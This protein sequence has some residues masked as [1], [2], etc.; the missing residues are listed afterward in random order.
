MK[1][2]LFYTI[3]LMSFYL[4]VLQFILCSFVFATGIVSGQSLDD[5]KLSLDLHDVS[6]KEAFKQIKNQ[7]GFNF[8]YLQGELHE[9]E[10]LDIH[11]RDK[12]LKEV[13]QVIA[14]QKKLD[15]KRV[16][17]LIVVKK[18]KFEQP[19]IYED[20]LQTSRIITGKIIDA[21]TG[22][23]LP[24]VNV[25]IKNTNTGV[26]N[27]I[28]GNY[29]IE[30][31][32]ELSILVF[33]SVG[34]VSQE[35]QI[36][37]Q[38]VINVNLNED[39]KVL[40]ELVVVGYGSQSGRD[41]TG[42]VTKIDSKSIKDFQ[43]S[44]FTEALAGQ[45]PGVQVL[46][47]TGVPGAAPSI[48]IRGVGSITA[49][50]EPLYVVDGFPMGN[51][52]LNMFNTNDIE[53][54]TVLKDASATSI[55]GSRGSNGVILITTKRG[56]S[57]KPQLTFDSYI[58]F[59]QVAKKMDVLSPEEYAEFTMDASNNGWATLGGNINDP[60]ELRPA[61]YRNSPYLLEPEKWDRTDWQDEIFRTAPIQNYEMTVSGGNEYVNY[62]VS[63]GY[64]DQDG[65]VENTNFKRYSLRTNIDTKISDRLKLGIGLNYS[66]IDEQLVSDHGTWNR[67]VIGTAIGLPGFFAPINEDGSYSDHRGF[68]FGVSA[69]RNPMIFI[70][71]EKRQ[72][73][74]SRL[75][76]NMFIEYEL[77]KGLM[78]R[79]SINAD[80]F[81]SKLNYFRNETKFGNAKIPGHGSGILPSEGSYNASSDLNWLMEN[82][83]NY[84][85]EL[86][87][88][89]RINALIGYTAQK[90]QL[91][92]AS[93]NANNFQNNLVP[94]LNA[95][96]VTGA[97]TNQ[98]EWSLLSYLARIN[99]SFNETY[100]ATFTVRRDGS[101]RFGADRKWGVFPSASI[102]WIV[103]EE[104]F[105]AGSSF[106][107][108]LKIR[109]SYGLSGNDAIPNYGSIGLLAG[110]DYVIGNQPI[111]GLAQSTISNSDLSWENSE[112]I[113]I[114]IEFGVLGNRI[115]IVAD[116]FQR[117]TQ[118]LLLNVNVPSILGF[119]NSLQ[120]IGKVRNRGM[121]LTLM[122]KNSTSE[123]KWST[124]FNI[125]FIRNKV[126]ALGP[127]GDPIIS[128]T[129]GGSSTHITQVGRPMGEFFGYI[130]DGIY[131]SQEEINSRPSLPTDEPGSPIILDVN[132]DNEITT[133]DRTVIGNHYPN[134]VYGVKNAFSY[135]NFDLNIFI[136]GVQGVDIMNVG[137]R[138][139][140]VLTGRTNQLG[141]ARERWR[142]PEQP[143][144]GKVP[145]ANIDVYGVVRDP[146]TF[147]VED[148]SYLRIRNVTIGYTLNRSL[149]DRIGLG[150]ARV[151]ASAMNLLTLSKN[152]DFNPEISTF[153]SGLTPGTA[154]I[155]YPVARTVSFGINLTF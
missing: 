21:Q 29:S 150:N 10:R 9:K 92:S 108:Y 102:G 66:L 35:I 88:N 12:S 56:K 85:L 6:I 114:G 45:V 13:L 129:Y 95:G 40:D 99:Y 151:Y 5:V 93:I 80:R 119:T 137:K 78:F 8:I 146:S 152:T 127:S 34:Y 1:T 68:G 73:D 44:T 23:P 36:G 53:S 116:L 26:I 90:A 27:D 7:T 63:G 143:G 33:S 144:N 15:F 28:D 136:Q 72:R 76:A 97:G 133:A 121:E 86:R 64:F 48:R 149:V 67:G 25:V 83:L 4:L 41:I 3:I 42:S 57:G 43:T 87:K 107:D 62:R 118:D 81:D 140:M 128:T 124:D 132:N 47:T 51:D 141:E 135:K 17:K 32:N 11:A 103:S 147:Y 60:N 148:G 134:F 49:G 84:D 14:N 55:Y 104:S 154:D 122:T 106:V 155:N 100:Y 105:M 58:G 50:N 20:T 2:R 111:T 123:F 142:S 89:H 24:G 120:N 18:S 30:V 91:G 145:K 109:G 46:Q 153:H 31:P 16:N 98:Q 110:Y 77:L 82:T 96:E 94:T 138:Q 39:S 19:L 22:T 74:Q 125:S 54:I 112:Q 79:S 65:V 113:D 37:N 38:S 117:I 70:N 52:A 139:T 131:N 115:L 69:A 61:F 59:Q 75:L 126:L 101:S 71:E 130:W